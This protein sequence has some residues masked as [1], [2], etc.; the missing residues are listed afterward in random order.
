MRHLWIG[1]AL[2][3]FCAAPTSAK[4]DLFVTCSD[5]E[6]H[7]GLSMVNG[8]GVDGLGIDIYQSIVGLCDEPQLVTPEPIP[9]P[10]QAVNCLPREFVALTVPAPIPNVVY[11]FEARFV[12]ESRNPIQHPL[13]MCWFMPAHSSV[14]YA[15]DGDAVTMRGR[16]WWRGPYFGTSY[17]V[18]II[19]CESGCWGQVG[20]SYQ[21][22]I[23]QHYQLA[24]LLPPEDPLVVDAF[25]LKIV[26]VIG[27]PW[28]PTGMADGGLGFLYSEVR[29]AENGECGP[30]PNR[31]M[32]WGSLKAQYR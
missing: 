24:S 6:A 7:I 4:I 11:R 18:Y 1:V 25:S 9:L 16:L 30:V 28:K 31:E 15:S 32:N 12:D 5:G 2:C 14:D 8:F 29:E 26:D 10:P 27:L 23:G 13:S 3:I 21:G 22:Q 20:G 19:P 17:N